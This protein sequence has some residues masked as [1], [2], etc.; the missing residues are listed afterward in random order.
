[1]QQPKLAWGLAALLSVLFLTGACGK[2]APPFLPRHPFTV[3]IEGLGC[4]RAEQGVLLTGKIVGPQAQLKR[5]ARVRI[6]HAYYP[7]GTSP[8]EG[9]P[10]DWTFLTEARVASTLGGERWCFAVPEAFQAGLHYFRVRA[11]SQRGEMGLPSE[12][13]RC[14]MEP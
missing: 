13:S 2:K 3:R 11:V 12:A 9:C 5:L 14:V 4:E 10:L 6:E 8:C 1:M 7:P